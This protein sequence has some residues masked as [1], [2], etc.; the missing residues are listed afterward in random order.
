MHRQRI[1]AE[2]IIKVAIFKIFRRVVLIQPVVSSGGKVINILP[3]SS[4]TG[5]R[6][7]LVSVHACGWTFAAGSS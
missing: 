6:G 3:I 1:V 5:S 4:A 7:I 2:L